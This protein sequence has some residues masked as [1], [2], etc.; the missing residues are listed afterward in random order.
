MAH[1]NRDKLFYILSKYK[2][3][4]SLGKHL[5]NVGVKGT[6]FSGH[7][8]DCIKI[9]NP[10]KFSIACE[11]ASY[12]GYTSEKLLT[13][14]AAHTVPIYWGDPEVSR[15]INPDCF[16][17][18]NKLDSLEDVL[19]I[20]KRIDEDDD[21]WATM[22]A[23]PW[24]LENQLSYHDLRYKNYISFWKNLFYGDVN[25]LRRMPKGTFPEWKR[26]FFYKANA[27]NQ[28]KLFFLFE[29]IKFKINN[30]S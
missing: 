23:S 19:E 20:V 4:D 12:L 11:N 5:N 29:K 17:D 16:I 10:Y 2:R 8:M 24:R 9:K 15:N 7:S 27:I 26:R 22:V 13:S 21:L 1:P 18:C 3:V 28:G 30:R 14:L 25:K 6:G